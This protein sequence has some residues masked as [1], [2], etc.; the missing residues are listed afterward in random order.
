MEAECLKHWGLGVRGYGVR[1]RPGSGCSFPPVVMAGRTVCLQNEV[2]IPIL[3]TGVMVLVILLPVVPVSIEG[4]L[5]DVF[6]ITARIAALITKK[7]GGR[8]GRGS[9]GTCLNVAL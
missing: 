8:A 2:D 3:M 5:Q 4:H 9:G 1:I 7:P 6:D